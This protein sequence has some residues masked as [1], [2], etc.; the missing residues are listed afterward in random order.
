MRD[1]RT[2]KPAQSLNL[3]YIRYDDTCDVTFVASDGKGYNSKRVLEHVDISKLVQ[4]MQTHIERGE[5]F[6]CPCSSNQQ[7]QLIMDKLPCRS[8]YVQENQVG[9]IGEE[10]KRT[11]IKRLCDYQGEAHAHVNGTRASHA[12][13]KPAT[14]SQDEISRQRWEHAGTRRGIAERRRLRRKAGDDR[15]FLQ[16]ASETLVCD[17]DSHSNA[18]PS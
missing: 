7:A 3:P 8:R 14:A 2:T 4:A 5:G 17:E 10:G 11:I 1:E 6:T 16:E 12:T 15:N 9:C 13:S 18:H